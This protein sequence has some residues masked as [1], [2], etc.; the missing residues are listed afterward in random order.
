M[1]EFFPTDVKVRLEGDKEASWA[2]RGAARN[3]LVKALIRQR[4]QPGLPVQLIQYLPDGG[5]ISVMLIDEQKIIT[6]NTIPKVEVEKID[7]EGV[8]PG[9]AIYVLCGIEKGATTVTVD[10]KEYLRSYA[11]S[12]S[13][14][15]SHRIPSGY[16]D[17]QRLA[18]THNQTKAGMYSGAMKRV[19]A[20]VE[21]LGKITDTSGQYLTPETATRIVRNQYATSSTKTQGI[22]KAGP[23]N[24]WLVEISA[25]NGIIAMPLPLINSTKSASYIEYLRRIGDT[26]GLEICLEFGG[27]PSG[28]TFPTGTD[29]TTA[30]T[31]GKVLRLKTAADL[32]GYYKAVTGETHSSPFSWA[33]N[34]SGNRAV[35]TRFNY[36]KLTGDPKFSVN[37]EL[38]EID[39]TLSLH[40]KTKVAP[41][42]VG[43]G[44]ASVS[45]VDDGRISLGCVRNFWASGGQERLAPALINFTS[46]TNV[47]DLNDIN[48]QGNVGQ[49]YSS[50]GWGA[51]IYAFFEGDRLELVK[52][53]PPYKWSEWYTV[54][55][56]QV[57]PPPSVDREKLDMNVGPWYNWS[58]S[59][60][61]ISSPG[62]IVSTSVDLR[63][64]SISQYDFG[65]GDWG[66][67][68]P[69]YIAS[70]GRSRIVYSNVYPF[71]YIRD[72]DF[73]SGAGDFVAT[74]T[75][76]DAIKAN[77]EAPPNTG[78]A[79]LE[80]L[81]YEYFNNNS[82]LAALADSAAAASH[83]SG[84]YTGQPN[85]SA[86]YF[87]MAP[88]GCRE[89][90]VLV[91]HKY[92]TTG[93]PATEEARAV[94]DGLGV[95]QVETDPGVIFP[96]YYTRPM[97]FGATINPGPTKAYVMTKMVGKQP[98]S[99]SPQVSPGYV[100]NQIFAN[101]S[102]ATTEQVTFIGSF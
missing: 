43:S 87:A 53:V 65:E 39:I 89:G 21:G 83:G 101:T 51:T 3:I 77:V 57:D 62:A 80:I 44:S 2:L 7:T 73:T 33:F 75:N 92:Q 32:D 49:D 79:T 46:L 8:E 24:H 37:A 78:G 85:Y 97:F 54:Q 61:R 16:H 6:I 64:L 28:E 50:E 96:P 74:P 20:A 98:D 88:G 76:F 47:M 31:R 34:N 94:F 59:G 84:S 1:S 71:P 19:V 42:P 29:L 95:Y 70:T 67:A 38:W 35:N 102:P 90:I 23:K 25:A 91:R 93:N 14:S 40:D 13:T 4:A 81:T 48:G 99:V 45:M 26:G 18:T 56:V 12:P 5:F 55:V 63:K 10:G 68:K 69:S 82:S 86:V 100:Y 9:N 22:Y 58:Y 30:I 60:G 66:T 41:N 36:K 27:L 17:N 11:P 15:K 72:L 52:Y